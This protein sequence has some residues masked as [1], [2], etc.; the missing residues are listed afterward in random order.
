MTQVKIV[1]ADFMLR[2]DIIRGTREP[3][4]V[5]SRASITLAARNQTDV[6][7]KDVLAKYRS[8]ENTFT[9]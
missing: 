2:C 1:A 9:E 6:A 3:G 7:N 4:L 5:S 8:G